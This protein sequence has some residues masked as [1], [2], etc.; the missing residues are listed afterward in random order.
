MGAIDNFRALMKKSD[1]FARAARYE[2]ILTPP[3]GSALAN[4]AKTREV[5]L[6]CDTIIMPGHTL[7]SASVKYGTA[8]ATEMVTGHAYEGTIEATFYLDQELD[9]KSFFDTWQESAVDTETNTVSYYKNKDNK[10]NYVTSMQIYQLGSKSRQKTN[11]NF[12]VDTGLSFDKKVHSEAERVYGI[13]VEEVY[14]TTIGGIE[15]AYASAGELAKL[16]VSFQYRR[17]KEIIDTEIGNTL[18]RSSFDAASIVQG[19]GFDNAAALKTY[20]KGQLN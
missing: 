8:V 10:H 13:N 4:S 3:A 20:L 14:P 9:V 1:G 2:V 15:Y 16:T 19:L 7:D 6:L 18:K 5:Q 12:D 11:I 17:W